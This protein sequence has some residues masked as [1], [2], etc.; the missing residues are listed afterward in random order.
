VLFQLQKELLHKSNFRAPN[1]LAN[2]ISRDTDKYAKLKKEF[3]KLSSTAKERLSPQLKIFILL[4]A[5]EQEDYGFLHK[6]FTSINYEKL[7]STGSHLALGRYYALVGNCYR[8]V[9]DY[10]LPHLEEDCLQIKDIGNLFSALM[11]MARHQD[12]DRLL[13]HVLQK[14]PDDLGWKIQALNYQIGISHLYPKNKEFITNNLKY[15]HSRCEHEKQFFAMGNCFFTAGYANESNAMFDLALKTVKPVL[16]K[17]EST[18]QFSPVKC[19]ETMDI[20]IDILEAEDI[21]VFPIAGS[22]LGLY[23]DGKFMDHDKDADVG[24]FVNGYDEV[25]RLV[26]KVCEQKRFFAPSM[27][28]NTKESNAWNVAVYDEENRTVVDFFFFYRQVEHCEFGVYSPCG[29]L[30][31][32][33]TP[34]ELVREELAG[35]DYWL[36]SDIEQHLVDMYGED[37]REPVKVWDSLIACP[38]LLPSSKPVV[39]YYSLIRLYKAL[40]SNKLEKAL[41]YY[42]LLTTR[43]EM[44]FSDETDTHIKQLISENIQ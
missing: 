27:I 15:L 39:F 12:C 37:W 21:K 25:L 35:R 16:A 40:E 28:K 33:F 36:P 22:L 19:R 23:R 29:I 6:L 24:I 9:I 2:T 20:M 1:S 14:Y 30:K 3:H 43:W 42:E 17:K 18:A 34:F 5:V 10:F 7:E 4:T 31:W 41:H 8:K 13:S 11:E 26:A 38:N 44:H 32:A